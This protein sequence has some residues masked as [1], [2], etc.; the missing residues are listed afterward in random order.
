MGE[1]TYQITPIF[2]SDM[3]LLVE[4]LGLYSVYNNKSHVKCCF[5]D[6]T[7]DKMGD[8]SI[9]EW[10]FR[11]HAKWNEREAVVRTL[12][13]EEGKEGRRGGRARRAGEEGGREEWVRR[14]GEQG[15][16]GEQVSRAGR[17]E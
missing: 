1:K 7:K 13:K 14:A 10:P 2:G 8:F 3:A 17:R 4:V 9:E 5:C 15:G 16:Q 6:C 11:S 12:S